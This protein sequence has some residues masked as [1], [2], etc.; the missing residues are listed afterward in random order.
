MKAQ[1]NLNDYRQRVEVLIRKKN[2]F[3]VTINPSSKGTWYGLP[4]GGIDDGETLKGA[5][6]R[7]TLEE[8]GIAIKDLVYS[9]QTSI[10]DNKFEHYKGSI[11]YLFEAQFDRV[12]TSLF[13]IEGDE[14][15]VLWVSPEKASELIA[16][17]IMLNGGTGDHPLNA[18]KKYTE[19]KTV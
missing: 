18:L 7:E 9:G 15:D 5:A 1:F 12:D 16:A 8:V 13:G 2:D 10:H 17:S 14:A 19:S 3:L 11:T 4:G 6:I